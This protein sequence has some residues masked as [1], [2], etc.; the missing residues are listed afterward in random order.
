M[1]IKEKEQEIR[2]MLIRNG[3]TRGV[4]RRVIEILNLNNKKNI[5]TNEK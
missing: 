3:D 4:V 1:T 5:K 2:D